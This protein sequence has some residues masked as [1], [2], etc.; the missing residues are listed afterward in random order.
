MGLRTDR[1]QTPAAYVT[2]VALLC[3]STKA[4]LKIRAFG[5]E[6]T[7][8]RMDGRTPYYT[9]S[10]SLLSKPEPK[11]DPGVRYTDGY[12]VYPSVPTLRKAPICRPH[13]TSD[14]LLSEAVST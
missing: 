13:N 3:S 5:T 11:S 9:P 4:E 2:T 6:I 10:Y 8:T 12:S 14:F 1:R 7:A